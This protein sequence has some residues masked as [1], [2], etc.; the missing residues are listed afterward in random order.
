MEK[1][2]NTVSKNLGKYHWFFLLSIANYAG[3]LK[4]KV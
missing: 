3:R 2:E 1:E 4:Q